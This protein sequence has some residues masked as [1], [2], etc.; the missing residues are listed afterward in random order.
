MVDLSNI[1]RPKISWHVS[2]GSLCNA[3]IFT[4]GLVWA[5][6][7]FATKATSDAEIDKAVANSLKTRIEQVDARTAAQEARLVAVETGIQ[8]IRESLTRI[9]RSVVK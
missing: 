9:E 7:A 3:V 5:V 6:S 8:Y 1:P 2:L 4:A